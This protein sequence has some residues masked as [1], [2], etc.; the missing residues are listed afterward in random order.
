MNPIAGTIATIIGDVAHVIAQAVT[1]N[2]VKTLDALAAVCPTA[3][4]IEARDKALKVQ[5]QQKAQDELG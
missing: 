1:S 3:A 5:Q 4:V 2:D